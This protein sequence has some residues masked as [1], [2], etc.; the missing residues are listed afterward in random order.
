MATAMEL[1]VD[2]HLNVLKLF[3]KYIDQSS[4]K[5]IN[6][7]NDI[8]FEDFETL[9]G[10]IHGYGVKGCTTYREGTSVA[11]LETQKK[12]SAK[13]VKAQQKEFLAAFND[14]ED[15]SVIKTD[16]K[17]PEEYPSK[18]FIL[19]S[20]GKKWYLHIAFKDKACTR[21]FAIFVNTNNK[22]DNVTTYNALE[23]LEEIARANG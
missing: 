18:G 22:E 16:V 10:K 14:Q 4:S 9:Y 20:E 1:S 8:S 2:E 13:S 19:R 12:E 17:L 21:P 23:T 3:A 5:T 7:P 15:G 6:L 11:I